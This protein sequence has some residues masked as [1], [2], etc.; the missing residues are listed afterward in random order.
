MSV[1]RHVTANGSSYILL[2]SGGET[3]SGELMGRV[4]NKKYFIIIIIITVIYV[5]I[6][7]FPFVF[8]IKNIIVIY[9]F[10][11]NDNSLLLPGSSALPQT[12]ECAGYHPSARSPVVSTVSLSQA[13]L[14][15]TS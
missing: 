12:P 8:V 10:I 14:P 2:G 3:V 4:K 13:P 11:S 9:M 6:S 7:F 1:V 5:L 15:G